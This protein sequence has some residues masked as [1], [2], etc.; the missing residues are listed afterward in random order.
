MRPNV[1]HHYRS[2]KMALWLDLI[3]K[4]HQSEDLTPDK[5]RLNNYNNVSTFED[6]GTRPLNHQPLFVHPPMPPTPPPSF[7]K[8]TP[9]PKRRSSTAVPHVPPMSQFPRYTPTRPVKAEK[10]EVK[11][12]GSK[13]IN[14]KNGTISALPNS[15]ESRTKQLSL[16]VIIAVGCSLLLLNILIFAGVYYQRDRMKMEMKAKHK[17]T[18][19]D[20]NLKSEESE[21]LK[22]MY[23]DQISDNCSF[24]SP[25]PQVAQISK[26]Q[27]QPSSNHPL[28][29]PPPQPPYY[30]R[31]HAS[32]ERNCLLDSPRTLNH[33]PVSPRHVRLVD[34]HELNVKH[35]S[36]DC[37]TDVMNRDT[38]V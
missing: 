34:T 1:R 26:H 32:H 17:D 28:P 24:T 23:S 25:P 11:D 38:V 30:A 27:V 18:E 21:P 14:P 33:K 5:H 36:S 8:T 13:S 20:S 15:N 31:N 37:G 16:S 2:S 29:I 22:G 19:R 10:N 7:R 6:E 3:P 4:L 12:A 9:R 35:S